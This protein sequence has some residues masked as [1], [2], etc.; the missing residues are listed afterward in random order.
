M[1]A[2]SARS[3]PRVGDDRWTGLARDLRRGAA[4]PSCSS[5]PG[6]VGRALVLALAPLPF[7]RALDRQP[8]RMP[9]RPT[10]PPNVDADSHAT[11]PRREIAAATPDAFVLVMT[12][13]HPLD[14]AITAAALQRG[15]PYVGPDR[16]RTPSGRG[17]RSAFGRSGSAAEPH[18]SLVCPIGLAGHRRQGPG[19]DRR[20]VT[21]QLLQVRE[22]GPIPCK[23]LASRPRPTIKA[24]MSDHQTED[25]ATWRAPSRSR[26]STWMTGA[27]GPFGA[28][29]V[30]DGQVLGRGLEPGHL[31]ERP[32]RPCG[33][34]RRSAGPARRSAAFSLEGA[35]LY[36]SC[37][38]CPMCLAS[39]YWARVSRIVFANTR[40][41]AA[42]IGFDDSLSTTRSR[43]RSSAADPDASTSPT[44]RP[45]P[46]SR[47]GAQGGQDRLLSRRFAGQ[48]DCLVR[49]GHWRRRR[50]VPL[51]KWRPRRC[52]APM[53]MAAQPPPH[54]GL[55]AF[56]RAARRRAR[57]H[58][59]GRREDPRR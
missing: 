28:V 46:S 34:R 13:D 42:A 37:E 52:S 57:G 19:R 25:R 14:L 53:L 41:D 5:A 32:D 27:G 17:S 8:A 20:L 23:S 16:Q 12:H 33:G 10:F 2:C 45:R 1:A 47:P 54:D 7:S 49:H 15:F 11:I 51:W 35:T 58:R 44:R 36:T 40:E 31:H 43:N 39:A 3:P 48:P 55:P 26:G 6:H 30:R 9:S 22:N 24:P 29:I 59:P 18:R 50:Q 56:L 21:A 4:P 38:P